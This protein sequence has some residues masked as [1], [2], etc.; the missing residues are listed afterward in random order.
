MRILMMLV[1]CVWIIGCSDPVP[2][3]DGEVG[4]GDASRVLDRGAP[5]GPGQDVGVDPD[6]H[7]MGS[8]PVRI[9]T[10]LQYTETKAGGYECCGLPGGG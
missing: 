5:L 10:R 6:P 1:C 2:T 8:L 3:V 4:K 7:R 9:F